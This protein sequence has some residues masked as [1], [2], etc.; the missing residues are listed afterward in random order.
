ML[1]VCNWQPDSSSAGELRPF[2]AAVSDASVFVKP[3]C[4]SSSTA[5]PCPSL[6]A[7]DR[8][9]CWPGSVPCRRRWLFLQLKQRIYWGIGLRN[10]IFTLFLLLRVLYTATASLHPGMGQVEMKC[11]S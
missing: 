7:G 3:H 2:P 11:S 9:L 4:C 1:I 8:N 6:R 5:Q 10:W